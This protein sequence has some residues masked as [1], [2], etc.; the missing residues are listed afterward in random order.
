MLGNFDAITV[1]DDFAHHPTEL[2]AVLSSAIKM[3]YK[4]V[5]PIFQP[6]TYSRTYHHCN[7]FVDVLSIPKNLIMTEILAVREKN[8][9]NISTKD[10]AVKLPGSVWFKTFEEVADYV[11][12]KAS[13]GDLILTIGGGDIY[14][15]A[16]MIVEKYKQGTSI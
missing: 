16:N 13:S 11:M 5:W 10:L 4:N 15:C 7:D 9:Y 3:G 6:H 8:I 14:K 1:A 12:E 2:K